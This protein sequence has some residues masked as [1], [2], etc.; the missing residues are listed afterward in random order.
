MIY[1]TVYMKS[2]WNSIDV[3]TSTVPPNGKWQQCLFWPRA[4]ARLTR[5]APTSP[6]LKN[7]HTQTQT[8]T[9]TRTHARVTRARARTHGVQSRLHQLLFSAGNSLQPWTSEEATREI[10]HGAGRNEASAAHHPRRGLGVRAV[11]ARP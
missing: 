4:S 7:T 1:Y 11:R 10:R 9:Y 5:P 6:P 2:V 3:R 8:H